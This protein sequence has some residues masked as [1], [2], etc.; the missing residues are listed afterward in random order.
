MRYIAEEGRIVWSASDLKAAAECEFAWLRAIDARLGRVP[1]VEEPEDLTLERAG[2][3]GNA[4]ERRVLDAYIARF[5]DGVVEITE[6]R[7]SDAVALADAVAQTV[8]ALAS[9]AAVIYQAAFATPDFVGFADFLVRDPSTA[10]AGGLDRAGHQARPSRARHGADAARRLRRPA[11]SARRRALRP[12]RAA[13]RRRH[14]ERARGR[15]SASR[16]PAP[17]RTAGLAHRRPAARPRRRR[18]ADRLGRRAR[19]ARRHRLRALRHV[20][21]RGRRRPRS[22]ARGRACA[23]CS[24]SGCAAP[25]SSRST[26]SR[27]RRRRP[28][29]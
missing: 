27:P 19:R 14:G 6:A 5:G 25:G 29:G 7:S 8:A 16:L 18:G 17:P 3:L 22:A 12:R 4:H 15:R 2:R 13:A 28:R 1:A 24:G 26:P 10:R 9:D 21:C 11:R 23:R 20:R